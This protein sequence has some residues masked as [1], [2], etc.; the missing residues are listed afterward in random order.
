M[1]FD[2]RGRRHRAVQVI[3]HVLALLIGGGLVLFGIGGSVSGGLLDAFNGGG[4]DNSATQAIEKRIET[5]QKKLRANPQSAAALKTL[6]R[7]N[8][9]LATAQIPVNGTTF[10]PEAQDDLARASDY[11]QR[12]IKVEKA[13]PDPSLASL[14]AQLYGQEALNRP[15]DAQ[16]A[17]RII[18]EKQ[19]DSNSYV[20]LVY[21][22]T[23]AGDTRTADLA[24]VK[25][26]DLAPAD[27]RKALK[28]QIADLKK[29]AA[30]QA[31]GGAQGG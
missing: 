8:Y 26:L 13:T 21:A 16:E 22:A 6:V 24:E 12:Y 4:G 23:V 2:L 27:T 18:A 15:K 30:A 9:Q 1:L 17:F 25:A 11:W 5:A 19:N 10:P 31:A 28:K 20:N 7:D 14:A 3:Y 29:Q